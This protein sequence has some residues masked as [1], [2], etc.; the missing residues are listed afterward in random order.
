MEH[1]GYVG[2]AQFSES[3]RVFHGRVQGIRDV[4]SYEGESVEALEA[5]F[6]A[7]VDHYLAMCAADGEEPERPFPGKFLVRTSPEV[8]RAIAST[9]AREG[10]SL[11][12][13][14]AETLERITR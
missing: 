13:W 7:A 10:K 12:A 1:R 14:V 8:H 5:D 6:R 3:D 9:A 11:N 4:V 2:S